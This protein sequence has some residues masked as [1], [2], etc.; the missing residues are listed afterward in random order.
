MDAK[1]FNQILNSNKDNLAFV[2]GNGI[3]RYGY[4][5]SKDIGWETLLL[6]IWNELSGRTRS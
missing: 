2:V 5:I 6:N 4:D 3:N 1:R